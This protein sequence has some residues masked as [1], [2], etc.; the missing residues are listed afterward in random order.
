MFLVLVN[1]FTTYN[2]YA[3]I[4][5]FCFLCSHAILCACGRCK[6][7]PR[8]CIQCSYHL[9]SLK[10][11]ERDICVNIETCL[12]WSYPAWTVICTSISAHEQAQSNRARSIFMPCSVAFKFRSSLAVI[13]Y[14]IS[15]KVGGLML[16][17]RAN[18][19]MIYDM[20]TRR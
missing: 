7:S 3:R 1:Y 10:A 17:Y 12:T 19:Y 2:C 15:E 9:S 18:L 8:T 11:V 14:N 6:M 4:N 5:Y 16:I 20:R 13:I